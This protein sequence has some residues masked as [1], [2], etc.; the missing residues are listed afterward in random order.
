MTTGR[1][2]NALLWLVLALLCPSLASAVAPSDEDLLLLERNNLETN[3][4]NSVWWESAVQYRTRLGIDFDYETELLS[5]ETCHYLSAAKCQEMDESFVE[6]AKMTRSIVHT[7]HHLKVLIVLVQWNDHPHDK[8]PLIP[9]SEI[10]LLWNGEGVEDEIF[11]SGSIKNYTRQNS[12]GNLEIE[13][14]IID[15]KVTNGTEAY[16]GAGRSGLPMEGEEPKL[17]EAF[18]YVLDQMESQGFPFDD[19]DQDGDLFIDSIMFV[20]SGYAADYGNLDC[21]VGTSY[22]DRIWSHAV[23][24]W[25]NDKWTSARTGVQLGAYSV[26]SAYRGFC[27]GNIALLGVMTH[28]FFHTLGLP[29]LYDVDGRYSGSSGSVGGL[30]GYDIMSNPR[31]PGFRQKYPGMLSPFCKLDMDWITPIEITE[32]GTYAARPSELHADIFIIKKGYETDEY[33]LIENRQPIGYDRLLWSGGILVYHIDATS[34]IRGNRDRGFPGANGWP[35]NGKHYPIALLQA[36]GN[37]DLEKASNNGHV[38]D[39]FRFPEQRLGPG[40]GEQ[41]ASAAGTYPNTDSYANYVRPTGII[42]DN[43]QETE[44]GVW[45]FRVKFSEPTPSPTSAPT[46]TCEHVLQVEVKTDRFPKETNW[47]LVDSSGQ[48]IMA[49]GHNR[50]DAREE[51]E[52]STRLQWSKCLPPGED[53]TFTMYDTYGDGFCC[54]Y[55]NGEWTLW[56]DD[57]VIG[58]GSSFSFR[59]EVAFTTRDTS[60]EPFRVFP[61][62][63]R[64][65]PW[66]IRWR[67]RGPN[68]NNEP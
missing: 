48:R 18:Q 65:R 50:E 21:E 7:T 10:D 13:A 47:E 42:I 29:D 58:T 28:E 3:N 43:F 34:T 15:W 19:Y 31:G 5:G 49:A 62:P 11:P 27:N 26:A 16:Y 56:L 32:D 45:S 55:G 64:S 44:P 20:H 66:F 12:Y 24:A 14:D 60:V 35:G 30:G 41:I 54:S 59:D 33:L 22:E 61:R 40:N 6:Q 25:R 9:A 53:F 2:T 17:R 36:D 4:N 51:L 52:P 67:P 39:F 38:D 46:E 37:Y 68:P 57:E 23:G 1:R 8:K 63:D